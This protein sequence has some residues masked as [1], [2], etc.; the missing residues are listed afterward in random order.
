MLNVYENIIG[1]TTS[2]KLQYLANFHVR[3]V[4]FVRQVLSY[5]AITISFVDITVLV[6]MFLLVSPSTKAFI[7][8]YQDIAN[9][10]RK[11]QQ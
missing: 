1:C 9:S 7:V 2:D 10:N 4:D 11:C 3:S 6:V 8:Q 5:L